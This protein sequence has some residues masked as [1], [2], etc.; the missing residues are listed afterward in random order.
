[1]S[2]ELQYPHIEKV[3]GQPARLQSNCRVR[4]AQLVTDYLAYGWSP[5]E[6][7][8]QYPHLSPA[9]VHSAMAYYFDHQDEIDAEIRDE[10]AEFD[11]E[12]AA[13]KNSP[14]RRA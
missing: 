8:R 14:I 6:I 10:L 7:C 12:H 3:A 13:A 1:M 9:E 4:V 5:D 2:V 11:R